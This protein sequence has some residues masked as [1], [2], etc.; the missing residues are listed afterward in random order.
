MKYDPTLEELI[1]QAA[2]DAY[3]LMCAEG[4]GVRHCART[5]RC[6]NEVLTL[7]LILNESA[8]SLHQQATGWEMVFNKLL[9]MGM[10]REYGETGTE[11]VMNF[12]DSLQN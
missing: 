12:L 8:E 10:T 11:R 9:S 7:R 3:R 1:E 6:G 2:F 4:S 5:V